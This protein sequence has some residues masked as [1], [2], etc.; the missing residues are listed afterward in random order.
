MDTLT[1]AATLLFFTELYHILGH[2]VIL[3]GIRQVNDEYLIIMGVFCV[4]FDFWSEIINT[5][6]ITAIS[7]FGTD[8]VL[9]CN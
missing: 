5:E 8:R 7:R 4:L 6:Q 3:F 1:V 2:S 9:L